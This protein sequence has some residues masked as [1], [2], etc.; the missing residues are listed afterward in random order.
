MGSDERL[1]TGFGNKHYTK[2]RAG[3]DPLGDDGEGGGCGGDEKD[4]DRE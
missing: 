3:E 4:R 2:G 1:S